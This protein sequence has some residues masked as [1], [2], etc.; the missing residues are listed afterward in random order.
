M[1]RT[2]SKIT[3]LDFRKA[4]FGLFR[5][6]LG[7]VPWDKAMERRRG[8]RNLVDTQASPPP[9]SGAVHPNEQEVRQKCH[10]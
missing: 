2:K 6:L 1:R 10:G 4:D 5:D 7:G 8:P 9:T 3:T